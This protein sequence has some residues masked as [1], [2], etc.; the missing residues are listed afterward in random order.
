MKNVIFRMNGYRIVE[1]REG[2]IDMDM[3]KGDCYNSVVNPD[4]CPVQLKEEEVQFERKCYNDG[5]YGY[6]LEKW[7]PE[8]N[9][10]WE[11]VDS[12]F[13][14]IGAHK[15]E[16]HYIVAELQAQI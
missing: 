4:M 6:V 5:V 13:G 14:F 11:H 16:N 12:C 3:L 1:V 10:G 15:E 9:C 7:N 2:N 8:I